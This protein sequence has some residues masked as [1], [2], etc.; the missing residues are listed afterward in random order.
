MQLLLRA[1]GGAILGAADC[2]DPEAI[3]GILIPAL[4]DV[5]ALERAYWV[6]GAGASVKPTVK[7]V[8]AA[9]TVGASPVAQVLLGIMVSAATPA[10]SQGQQARQHRSSVLAGWMSAQLTNAREPVR[11]TAP[12]NAAARFCHRNRV[13]ADV[14]SFFSSSLKVATSR[15]SLLK[16]RDK[17]VWTKDYQP[18]TSA[19][20][21][22]VSTVILTA[23]STTVST[24]ASTHD[25]P[26][27]R[28]SYSTRVAVLIEVLTKKN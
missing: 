19:C 26:I 5:W 16:A 24:V 15:Q 14:F 8:E 17:Q 23:V 6:D 1:D 13:N 25:K 4:A 11:R 22:A 7:D 9:F 28:A 10:L 3:R 2:T 12:N 18:P 21:H 20:A 27:N